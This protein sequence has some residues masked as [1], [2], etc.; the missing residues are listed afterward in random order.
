[1]STKIGLNDQQY[2]IWIVGLYIRLLWTLLLGYHGFT[3]HEHDQ[4][5]YPPSHIIHN[6]TQA[7]LT[8]LGLTISLLTN[9]P[10]P[11]IL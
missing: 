9:F 6:F 3:W 7:N 2:V 4:H 8:I 10:F 11:Q 1:M 5:Y